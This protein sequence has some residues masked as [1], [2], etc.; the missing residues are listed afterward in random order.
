MASSSAQLEKTANLLR[1]AIP[2]MSKLN[3]PLTPE[4]YHVWYKYTMGGNLELNKAIDEL[5]A[6]GTKFTSKVNHEL[7]NAY[8]Y[9]APE[10]LLT[11]FHQ[12]I[13]K[14]VTKLFEKITGMANK[15]QNYSSTLEE[16]ND[17]LQS[18]PDIDTLTNL[19]TNLIDATDQEDIH[20]D[21]HWEI[22]KEL[23]QT[24]R[25]LEEGQRVEFDVVQ[26]QKGPQ[27]ENVTVI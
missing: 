7:H 3:I 18:D 21:K 16:Y 19:L 10:E 13:Q 2:I 5:L 17:V 11:S 14:M 20:A 27:A 25:N 12:D 15:T 22:Y 1:E 9:Q 4:N 8:V 23:K 6:N 24:Y 26:G